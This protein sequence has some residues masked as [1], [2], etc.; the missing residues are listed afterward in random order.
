MSFL[1][2]DAE[3]NKCVEISVVDDDV[4]LEAIEEWTFRLQATENLNYVLGDTLT[5]VV[6]VIDDDGM[7]L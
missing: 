4:A 3:N 2:T 1:P 5:A 7:V 6:Q